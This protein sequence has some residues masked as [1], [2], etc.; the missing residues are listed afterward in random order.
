M[1][2]YFVERNLKSNNIINR[3]F[4]WSWVAK[5]CSIC[6]H[7]FLLPN[8]YSCWSSHW[9]CFEFACQGK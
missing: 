2:Y 6:K 3:S 8:W 7:R 4:C 5:D 1:L 9:C